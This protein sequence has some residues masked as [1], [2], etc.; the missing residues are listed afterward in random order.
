MPVL[1]DA[2]DRSLALAAAM[3]S[4]GYGRGGDMPRRVRLGTGALVVTGLLGVCVG[5]YGVLD[6][7]TPRWLGLPMLALGLV[8]AGIGLPLAGRRIRRTVYR[9][10]RWHTAET[11]VAASGL[12]AV[13]VL[14]AGGNAG[15]HPSVYPPAWPGLPLLGTAGVLLAL[16]PAF[17][18]PAPPVTVTAAPDRVPVGAAR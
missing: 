2:L 3:D 8:V 1:V 9:P 4:R 15:L 10:D 11:L 7:T 5:V 6:G 13:A 17:V 12:G 16:L 18:A 14:I